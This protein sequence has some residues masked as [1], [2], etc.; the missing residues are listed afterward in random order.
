MYGRGG[1]TIL[2]PVLGP[3][4]LVPLAPAHIT[5]AYPYRYPTTHHLVPASTVQ[6]NPLIGMVIIVVHQAGL[7]A[8]GGGDRHSDVYLIRLSQTDQTVIRMMEGWDKVYIVD[9]SKVRRMVGSPPLF[10]SFILVESN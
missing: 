10:R 7:A 1:D 8:N 4:P 9:R 2:Y 3:Y 6:R 5:P